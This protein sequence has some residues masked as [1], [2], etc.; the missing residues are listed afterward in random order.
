MELLVTKLV[1]K[2]VVKDV[3][4]N[5]CGES[6]AYEISKDRRNFNS[7]VITA[8]FGYGSLIYDMQDWEVHI[9]EPCYASFEATFKIKPQNN[10]MHGAN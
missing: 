7:A 8:D 10:K 5:K 6:C 3:L 9:C 1:E 4:C 2:Q